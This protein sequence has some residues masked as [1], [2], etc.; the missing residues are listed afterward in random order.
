MS[1]KFLNSAIKYIK[2]L[3]YRF[4]AGKWAFKKL[5]NFIDTKSYEE[6][7]SILFQ[8]NCEMKLLASRGN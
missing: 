8:C 5:L 2:R 1:L 6:I 4:G 7:E 3:V